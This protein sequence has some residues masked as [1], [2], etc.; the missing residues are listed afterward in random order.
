[1]RR[2][3]AGCASSVGHE[4]KDRSVGSL[5]DGG[6]LTASGI[7]IRVMKGDMGS[8]VGNET[9]ARLEANAVADA[10]GGGF[11]FRHP[12][13]D[14]ELIVIGKAHKGAVGMARKNQL[15]LGIG[16]SDGRGAV[17][18]AC[19]VGEFAAVDGADGLILFRDVENTSALFAG[20]V[21]T[22]GADENAGRV[23]D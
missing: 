20:F 7:S 3:K 12:F 10:E 18:S 15:S 21:V 14:D 16:N 22:G 2:A 23:F 6:T 1:M 9:V 5:T 17:A 13:G 8:V 11:L 19:F 4:K